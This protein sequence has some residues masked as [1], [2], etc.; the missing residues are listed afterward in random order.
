MGQCCCP[1]VHYS[2]SCYPDSEDD[3]EM[4]DDGERD[5]VS[6]PTDVT[7]V[8]RT[9]TR[10]EVLCANKTFRISPKMSKHKFITIVTG[11][12]KPTQQDLE[13]EKEI[14]PQ[15]NF[16][17]GTSSRSPEVDNDYGYFSDEL[18]GKEA[19]STQTTTHNPLNHNDNI[20]YKEVD[21]NYTTT[22]DLYSYFGS[23]LCSVAPGVE[24]NPKEVIKRNLIS[25]NQDINRKYDLLGQA[26]T[27]HFCVRINETHD[28]LFEIQ[29]LLET[30][31]A[32]QD[33]IHYIVLSVHMPLI[34]SQLERIC[35]KKG[36]NSSPSSYIQPVPRSCRFLTR[37]FAGDLREDNSIELCR[38]AS[39]IDAERSGPQQI[40]VLHYDSPTDEWLYRSAN[41]F[42]PLP[43][44]NLLIKIIEMKRIT[45]STTPL[46]SFITLTIQK[47]KYT[48][49]T[50]KSTSNYNFDHTFKV[51]LNDAC[52]EEPIN[53]KVLEQQKIMNKSCCGMID[54]PPL[55]QL[56]QE[57]NCKAHK[58]IISG[59]PTLTHDSWFSF[60]D[61]GT[62]YKSQI[63]V[64]ICLILEW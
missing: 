48:T 38:F 5:K 41:C 37:I 61:E 31:L 13:E 15:G 46:E 63:S 22:C 4:H 17:R 51:T 62:E 59:T 10:G 49:P 55:L 8:Y 3:E 40:G 36:K 64:R 27:D 25:I 6:P 21:L 39:I 29:K 30:K 24:T 42:K 60:D 28:D 56:F 11:F 18:V 32:H 45:N 19:A 58:K 33:G 12:V 35:I 26:S 47:A 9:G 43:P 44:K 1:S 34:K 20:N 23:K 52:F 50:V 16:K 53:V 57:E 54:L 7:D 2:E 14:Q